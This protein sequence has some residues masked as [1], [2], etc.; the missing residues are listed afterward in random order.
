MD[1]DR[2][3]ARPVE[4]GGRRRSVRFR[5]LESILENHVR[6]LFPNCNHHGRPHDAFTVG[7][8]TFCIAEPHPGPFVK[9]VYVDAFLNAMEAVG[10]YKAEE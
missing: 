6:H 9:K 10:L 3:R 7:D 2:I 5:E 4:L 1:R 8:Q